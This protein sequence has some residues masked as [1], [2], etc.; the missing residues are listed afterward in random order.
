M[1][2]TRLVAFKNGQIRLILHNDEW[3]KRNV[4]GEVAYAQNL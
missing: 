1:E 2:E 3:K 4:Q